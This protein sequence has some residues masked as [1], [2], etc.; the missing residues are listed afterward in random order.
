VL[1]RRFLFSLVF[2]ALSPVRAAA[3]PSI[4]FRYSDGMIW[5]E[6]AVA[7]RERP[8]NFLLDSGASATVIDLAAARSLGLPMG[9]GQPVQGVH[10]RATAYPVT[11]FGGSV[12][13]QSICSKPLALDLSAVSAGCGKRIDGL[14]GADFFRGRIVK[15]DF[16]A[17]RLHLLGS[18]DGT[19]AQSAVLP[20]SWRNDAMCVRGSVGKY[21]VAWLRLDTGCNSPAQFVPG[22]AGAP[23]SS[24]TSVGLTTGN[25]QYAQLDLQLGSER[26]SQVKVGLHR[27]PIFPGESGLLGTGVLARF[28]SVTFDTGRNLLI[29]SK[30]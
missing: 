23:A 30:R 2:F 12:A 28:K 8:L 25:V 27:D 4:P 17:S 13:G 16:A 19:G 7:G 5:L 22:S 15:I 21:P 10:S 11:A 14:V 1:F 29:L 9:A 24:G 26:V 6:V 3:E 18:S 20:I